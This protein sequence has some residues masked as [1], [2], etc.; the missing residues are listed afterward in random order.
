MGY[1]Q[2][3]VE[4]LLTARQVA[5]AF[6]FTSPEWV[7]NR[8][9]QTKDPIPCYRLGAGGG[10]VR[11]RASEIEAWLST[12]SLAVNDTVVGVRSRPGEP[13]RLRPAGLD[14]PVER[15]GQRAS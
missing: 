11:F 14:A 10:P 8:A 4:R 9:G 6:G 1:D 7:L 2:P 5:D 13:A 12:R 15:F 3:A